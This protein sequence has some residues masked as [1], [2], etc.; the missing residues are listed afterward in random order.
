MTSPHKQCPNERY[1]PGR[2]VPVSRTSRDHFQ[3]A[4]LEVSS[5][6]R[7]FAI[8]TQNACKFHYTDVKLVG[9]WNL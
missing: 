6:Y 1:D 2:N 3:D 5:A 4:F 9:S 7:G 8:E